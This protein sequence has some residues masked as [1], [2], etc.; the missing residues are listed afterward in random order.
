MNS[1]N[2][3]YPTTD[4]PMFNL[5]YILNR[6]GDLDD[7]VTLSYWEALSWVQGDYI[8]VSTARLAHDLQVNSRYWDRI[9]CEPLGITFRL[10]VPRGE[11]DIRGYDR[12]N[13]IFI[14]GRPIYSGE[15][16][17]LRALEYALEKKADRLL[18]DI[19]D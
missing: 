8:P 12:D 15:R 1:R 9:Y 18:E 14:L 10:I 19:C 13:T 5:I 11:R 16:S 7:E 17:I 4:I 6:T 2:P 3:F